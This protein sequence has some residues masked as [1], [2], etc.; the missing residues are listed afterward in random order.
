[1]TEALDDGRH[2]T[3]LGNFCLMLEMNSSA[4]DGAKTFTPAKSSSIS[5]R[6][7]L[8]LYAEQ[9]AKKASCPAGR[10]ISNI[11]NFLIATRII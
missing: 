2:E 9:N 3:G 7:S 5:S 10:E 1:M 11:P 8:N 4:Q 6:G